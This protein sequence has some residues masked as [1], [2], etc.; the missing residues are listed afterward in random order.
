MDRSERSWLEL[1]RTELADAV[2][3]T[4]FRVPLVGVVIESPL[5]LGP[6]LLTWFSQQDIEERVSRAPMEHQATVRQKYQRHYQGKVCVEGRITAVPSKAE[7]FALEAAEDVVRGL[8]LVHPAAVDVGQASRL[9]VYDCKRSRT[10]HVLLKTPSGSRT[11]S[12]IEP[13]DRGVDLVL[14][15]ADL[16]LLADVGLR[17][18]DRFLSTR[19]PTKLNEAAWGA[20]DIF[21]RGVDSPQWRD[22]LIGALVAA[23]TLLLANSTE[24]IQRS[25]GQRIAVLLGGTLADKRKIIDDIESAYKARSAFIHHGED[26]ADARESLSRA[27][28]AC[29]EVVHYCLATSKFATKQDLI[30]HLDDQLLGGTTSQQ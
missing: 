10:P 15:S 12:G 25:L 22:R 7:A 13:T 14:S 23:E 19:E 9:D 3:E 8:R 4:V 20:L 18:V 24:P 28:A 30:R 2:Q 11:R 29:R 16:Q 21:G 1:L 5:S 27:V 17:A 6:Y 26:V